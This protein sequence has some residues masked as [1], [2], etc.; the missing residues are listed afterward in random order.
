MRIA[1]I[2]KQYQANRQ[3]N[4]AA[5]HAYSSKNHS[6]WMSTGA[7]NPRQ[8][9]AMSALGG[10]SALGNFSA[11]GGFS[12][13]YGFSAFS[14]LCALLLAGT[15]GAT[16]RA[17]DSP[18]GL[19]IGTV[20]ISDTPGQ[21]PSAT[22]QSTQ[23]WQRFGP[24]YDT[25]FTEG[26]L[27][28]ASQMSDDLQALA[29]LVQGP[30]AKRSEAFLLAATQASVF[31]R[32]A[33]PAQAA[34][35]AQRALRLLPASAVASQGDAQAGA[36]GSAQSAHAAQ[37]A[38]PSKPGKSAQSWPPA[39]GPQGGGRELGHRLF[40]QGKLAHW[41]TQSGDLEGALR[42]TRD[43]VK[44]YS[45]K[46]QSKLAVDP[47]YPQQLELLQ[48]QEH[49]VYLLHRLGRY[50]Q[51]IALGQRLL[52]QARTAYREQGAEGELGSLLHNLAQSQHARGRLRQARQFAQEGLD[53]ALAHQRADH[54]Y[55]AYAQLVVL[56]RELGRP[57]DAQT[58]LQAWDALARER[59]DTAELAQVARLRAQTEHPPARQ[60][61]P[62]NAQN[63]AH[64][65]HPATPASGT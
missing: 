65:N 33:M 1:T 42:A 12:A 49:E 35:A 37:S 7:T 14:A 57:Q 5:G 24:L 4:L 2:F 51:A 58:W 10:F 64:A 61:A 45:V 56:S 27:F 15:A 62:K 32:R 21:R 25:V 18:T 38:Q 60:L 3:Q 28:S 47:A 13:L 52:P 22:V 23:F 26:T 17:S 31:D 8:I 39:A 6:Y 20:Y 40:L 63:R 36:G 9:H 53:L 50:D 48:A 29:P 11:L 30:Q 43:F 19:P 46:T 55:D 59:A 41:L 44:Q 34:E 16:P 54:A